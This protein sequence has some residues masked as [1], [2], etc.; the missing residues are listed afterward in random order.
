MGSSI[1]FVIA[2]N[3]TTGWGLPET[4]TGAGNATLT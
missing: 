2:A 1:R 4:P 3:L